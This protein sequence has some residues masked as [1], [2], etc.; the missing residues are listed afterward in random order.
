MARRACSFST[1]NSL[2]ALADSA[3]ICAHFSKLAQIE[4][5][6][7]Q[8]GPFS[9]MLV[10]FERCQFGAG[11]RSNFCEKTNPDLFDVIKRENARR[12]VGRVAL[13]RMLSAPRSRSVPC[14]AP[15]GGEL[16]VMGIPLSHL[17]VYGLKLYR[18]LSWSRDFDWCYGEEHFVGTTAA[19]QQGLVRLPHGPVKLDV[20]S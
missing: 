17:R 2:N 14:P 10:A 4:P 20:G 15:H 16:P 3:F 6:S 12:E 13:G 9:E 18:R 5:V 1:P 8:P 7:H 11:L 19:T